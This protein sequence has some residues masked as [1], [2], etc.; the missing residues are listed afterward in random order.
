[1]TDDPIAKA[2]ALLNTALSL[3][4][5]AMTDLVNMRVKCNKELASHATIQS[6]QYQNEYR[7]G[8]LGLMNGALSDSP[9]GVIG[10]EGPLDE[11]TGRFNRIKR[12]VDLRLER[13]DVLT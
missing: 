10:A 3:D 6:G 8:F 1:M 13:L 5:Q 7:V 9:T 2:I 4:P 11:T 12:F